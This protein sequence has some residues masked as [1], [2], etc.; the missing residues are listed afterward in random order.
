MLFSR[1]VEASLLL[2][3]AYRPMNLSLSDS[4]SA[5]RLTALI[6]AARLAST[7]AMRPASYLPLA[8]HKNSPA[9]DRCHIPCVFVQFPHP[10][11]FQP[12]A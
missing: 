7:A 10:L 2:T 3:A 1:A 12:A 6:Q 4:A 5:T 8:A 9:P 11:R